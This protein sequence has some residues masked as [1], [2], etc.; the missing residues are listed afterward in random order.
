MQIKNL[1]SEIETSSEPVRISNYVR[2]LGL[3]N[4][5]NLECNMM[6]INACYSCFE[7]FTP[8]LMMTA[9]LRLIN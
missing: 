4:I 5:M 8:I 3:C 6:H 9:R 7:K 2:Y 1:F